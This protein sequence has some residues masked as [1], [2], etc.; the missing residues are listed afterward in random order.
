MQLA[1]EMV[2]DNLGDDGDG[3]FVGNVGGGDNVNC[4]AYLVFSYLL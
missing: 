3:D 1:V 4:S 2:K